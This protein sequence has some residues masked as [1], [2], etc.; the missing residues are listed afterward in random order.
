MP[1][2]QVYSDAALTQALANPLS[3]DGMGNYKFLRRAGRYMIEI[4]GPGIITKANPQRHPAERSEILQ[5]SP[6]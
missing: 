2:A 5:R 6:I 1:L 4:S 3:A